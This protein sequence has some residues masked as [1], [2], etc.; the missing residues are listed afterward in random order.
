MASLHDGGITNLGHVKQQLVQ[1]GVSPQTVDALQAVIDDLRSL[2][3]RDMDPFDL[4][5][6]LIEAFESF[7]IE[8]RMEGARIAVH[9]DKDSRGRWRKLDRDLKRAVYYAAAEAVT[10]ALAADRRAP[11]EVTFTLNP[12][13]YR[14]VVADQ[15][16]GFDTALLDNPDRAHRGLSVMRAR[17]SAIGGDDGHLVGDRRRHHRHHLRAC[18]AG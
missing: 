3:R 13:S 9:Y 1:Q 8:R 11:V 2:S 4:T 10:N 6:G 18:C 7:C 16:P 14:V 5:G 15:G 12:D 17:L